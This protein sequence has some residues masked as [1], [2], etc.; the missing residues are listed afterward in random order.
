M[1]FE[2]ACFL[3]YLFMLWQAATSSATQPEGGNVAPN[4]VL[5]LLLIVNQQVGMFWA[6][7]CFPTGFWHY[8]MLAAV[9]VVNGMLWCRVFASWSRDMC[10][11]VMGRVAAVLIVPVAA[12]AIWMVPTLIADI[13][14]LNQL[15]AQLTAQHQQMERDYVE[16]QRRG[17]EL[18]I[19]LAD[20]Q[21][22]MD[23]IVK[24]AV[25]AR[26]GEQR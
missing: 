18:Q 9:F 10:R 16:F 21:S 4:V 19:V 7:S 6:G 3:I 24:D 13:R 15:D 14:H 5:V 8:F 11:Q 20:A 26:Y 23:A 1:T 12:L 17:E 22:S 25:R 2:T